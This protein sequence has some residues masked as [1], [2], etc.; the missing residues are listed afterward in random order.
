MIGEIIAVGDELTS[1]RIVN[2][3]SAFAARQ[4]FLA[5]H[6]VLAMHT[7]GDTRQLIGEA[8]KRAIGR[9]DFVLV[10][11]GLGP[12]SDDLTNEAAA[13]AL[14]RPA[15]LRREILERIQAQ[16]WGD[17]C[18][19]S[20][21]ERLAWL[22][23]GAEMLNLEARTCGHLL[24]H[25]S[26]PVFFLPGV[27]GQAVK[28]LTEAVL[29]RLA[30]WPGGSS[31]AV[32][33]RLYRTAGLP[34]CEINRRLLLLEQEEGI[35]IGYYPV[36]SEV[37]VSLTTSGAD[38]PFA[39][40]DQRIRAAL[41]EHL[42]GTDKESLANSVGQLLLRRG[43]TLA[44]AE[45]CTGGLISAKITAVPGCSA[46]FAGGVVAYSNQLKERL[47]NVNAEL[48]R[49]HGAVSAAVAEAMAAGMAQRSGAAAAVAVTGIA[50]PDGGTADKP[51]GTVYIGLHHDN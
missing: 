34:E 16:P 43:L 22:P 29:P 37:H 32:Q 49:Q 19:Q 51:V 21:L 12:T 3:T 5:G 28:L 9:A 20:D 15:T 38:L 13:E 18:C 1:G 44:V 33:M 14:G 26:V 50:G 25:D 40:A 39:D 27:P 31:N 23:E 48:L 30:L 41:G 17:A 4:L 46:W 35:S 6:T 24:V 7:V 8:L 10:T 45:S 42:Y 47:L 2:T 36:E 11:G